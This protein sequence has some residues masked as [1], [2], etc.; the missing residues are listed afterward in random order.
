[1]PVTQS[2]VPETAVLMMWPRICFRICEMCVGDWSHDNETLVFLNSL[3]VLLTFCS[4]FYFLIFPFSLVLLLPL[5][6]TKKV[7]CLDCH[8]SSE[9]RLITQ[10]GEGRYAD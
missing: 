10:A 5:T 1:M 7:A 6:I 8:V 4:P 9:K 2:G 3:S